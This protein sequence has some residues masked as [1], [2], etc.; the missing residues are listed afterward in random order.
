M[1][2]CGSNVSSTHSSCKV[3]HAIVYQ[4]TT[5]EIEKQHTHIQKY[6]IVLK[7]EIVDE[8]NMKYGII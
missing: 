2:S 3:P 4:R 6:L 8:L 7:S 5:H 1:T